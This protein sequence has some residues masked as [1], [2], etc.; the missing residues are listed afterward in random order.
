MKNMGFV[1]LRIA[2]PRRF[3]DPSYFESES[4]KMA[5]DAEDV[6]AAREE[7][8]AIEAAVAGDALVAGATGRPPDGYR[9]LPPRQ[10]APLLLDAA[11]SGSVA[12]L[13]GQESI[14]LTREA[15]TRCQVLGSI[16]TSHRY[17]SLNLAQAT[18]L[19]LY[20]IRMAALDDAPDLRRQ[21]E[22]TP[23]GDASPPA[24]E[25]IEGFYG[26]L[27]T[28][29]DAIGFFEGSGRAHMVRELRRIF[30]RSIETRR[31]LRIL[32]GIVNRIR[33]Q[34]PRG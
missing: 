6:L 34:L 13:F 18:L 22:T 27:T 24:R 29:L 31:E 26:R 12:L 19:F 3:D 33:L 21:P 30:N 4:R 7:H 9:V 28:T 20:E 16:P 17:G 11:R 15:M 10:L 32:E 23:E 1:S 5:W 2:E 14:G 25:E 8:P